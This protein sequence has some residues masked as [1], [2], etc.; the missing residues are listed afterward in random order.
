[1]IKKEHKNDS[2]QKAVDNKLANP[3]LER[4]EEEKRTGADKKD[5]HDIGIFPRPP[6]GGGLV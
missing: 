3:E 6:L 2:P 1:M 4:E 5:F